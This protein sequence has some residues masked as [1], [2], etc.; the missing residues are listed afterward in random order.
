[1]TLLRQGVCVHHLKRCKT[2]ALVSFLRW[3]FH[4][5]GGTGVTPVPV[6]TKTARS[7]NDIKGRRPFDVPA[8]FYPF[9]LSIVMARGQAEN[10]N[11]ILCL[12]GCLNLV[13]TI[14]VFKYLF[15]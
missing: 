14:H 1:M 2:S 10:P 5:A 15:R 3:T 6:P 11:H 8:V 13:F 9:V 12:H 7:H 4:F